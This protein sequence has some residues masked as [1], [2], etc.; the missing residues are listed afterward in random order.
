VK[1]GNVGTT[2]TDVACENEAPCAGTPHKAVQRGKVNDMQLTWW[3][4][5]LTIDGVPI[6]EIP[7]LDERMQQIRGDK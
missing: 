3:D 6:R 4:V 1:C 5:Q 2:F 7:E